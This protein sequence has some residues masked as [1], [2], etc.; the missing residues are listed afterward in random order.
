MYSRII[1][2]PEDTSFFLFGPR[3]TGKSTWLKEKFS[4]ALLFDLL[5]SST[6]N[7]LLAEPDRLETMIPTGFK[8]W[9]IL[10]EV[11]KI[12]ALLNEVH[13]LIENRKLKFI[14]TG[15]SARK[16]KKEDVNLLAGRAQTCFMH[17]LTAQELGQDFR[18]S[19]SLKY[20]HLPHT[21]NVK[22][23]QKYLESYLTTYLKEEIQQ[24]GLTRNLGA[25]H[26][27]LEVASFSQ[28]AIINF[29]EISRECSVHRKVVE[30]YFTILEDLLIGV[31]LPV[32]TK[33]AKRKMVSH[34]KFYFFDVG[35]YQS[36]RPKGPLDS[37]EEIG[38]SALETLIFQEIRASNDALQQGYELFFWHTADHK[39]VDFVLYGEKGI[40]A[41]EV[42][43]TRKVTTKHLKGLRAFLEDYPMATAYLV[44]GGSEELY[45]DKINV[46]PVE[47]FLRTLPQ[48]F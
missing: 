44:Y 27:F 35:V 28:G 18:L 19:H 30:N 6:F 20:G 10:D 4:D 47:K 48:I 13:R 15:S 43:A 32:F 1:K 2:F 31:R 12:P 7:S 26:R 11:Q 41:I 40:K 38:G 29:S 34:S 23:P 36:L 9:V 39:E 14:L 22:D 5:K 21:F 25:F 8:N 24:E 42:K 37:P 3:G 17:P 16:L 33:K 45:F 46:I